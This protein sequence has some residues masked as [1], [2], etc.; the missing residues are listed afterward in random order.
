MHHLPHVLT[1]YGVPANGSCPSRLAAQQAVGISVGAGT[2][3]G[4]GVRWE[5]V[6][7]VLLTVCLHLCQE[8][9]ALAKEV[10]N[11]GR[12]T[13]LACSYTSWLKHLQKEKFSAGM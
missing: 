2:F 13:P 3:A 8:D 6:S 11:P 10:T 1:L 5:G 12:A 4:C 7:L 9:R